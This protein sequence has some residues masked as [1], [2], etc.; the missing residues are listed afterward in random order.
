LNNCI[1]YF[2][3]APAGP[4]FSGSTLN[5]CCTT[6]LPGSGINNF[7]NNPR[8]ADAAHLSALSPCTGAGSPA[9]SSGV[10]IDGEAWR[11]P[12]AIG[13]DEYYS[14]SITGA[15]GVAILANYTNVSTGFAVH[16][17]AQ[18]GGHAN[19]NTWNFG[20]G[21]MATNSPYILHSWSA[22]GN[23]QVVLTAYNET[24]PGGLSAT[25]TV[26]VTTSPVYYVA[27]TSANPVAPYASWATAATNIQDAVNVAIAGSTVLVSN[28]VYQTGGEAVSG[29]PTNR[30][31]IDK[32]ITVQSVNGLAVTVIQGNPDSS[33]PV[34]CVY[35]ANHTTLAGFTLTNGTT[36]TNGNMTFEQSGGGIWCESGG[37]N[38]SNCLISGNS[39]A[40]S[41]GGVFRGTLT[42]CVISGNTSVTSGGGVL[43]STLNNCTLAGNSSYAGGGASGSTLTGCTLTNNSATTT[44]YGSEAYGG[45]ADSST[46]DHCALAGNSADEDGGG[47]NGSTLNNCLITGNSA[48]FGGGVVSS[49]LNNC[50]VAGNFGAGRFSGE[51]GGGADYSTLNNCIVYYNTLPAQPDYNDNTFTACCLTPD[52]GGI[53]DITNEPAFVNLAGGDF[54]LQSNSPCINAGNNSYVPGSTDLDGNSRIVAGTVDIGAYEYQSPVSKVSYAW[55]VQYGLPIM[56]GI[57]TSSPNGT[58]FTVY[59]DW[60]AGLNPTDPTSRLVMLPLSPLNNASGFTVTWQSVSGIN[61]NLQR[62]TGLSAPFVTIQSN[63][64]GQAG[65]TS[66]T[67]T[68]AT[69]NTPY[70]YRVSVP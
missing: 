27:L 63:I 19:R 40:A 9:Y 31:V 32:P 35:L 30:V 2:N 15:L 70:F 60:I 14:G 62:S 41:G 10:D 1:V 67:D 68:T 26:H 39:A 66:Y 22:A 18:M 44:A 64:P 36:A 53:G 45:G 57:D 3:S 69:N 8:M 51:G 42:G 49:T 34:R 65:T 7:T 6:P 46:L 29:G 56:N 11:N 61:Y 5:F 33:N 54:H 13:C 25:D 43:Q 21:T 48:T 58:G 37:A 52:F 55:L 59:Q 28:G 17:T 16:F 20:D 47:A 24:D 4:N 50:T 38:I 12:P 23:Y